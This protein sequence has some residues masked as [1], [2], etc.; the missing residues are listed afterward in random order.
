LKDPTHGI[1]ALVVSCALAITAGAGSAAT[2]TVDH[3]GDG[4][5][6]TLQE[7]IDAASVGDTLLVAPG[8][9]SGDGNRDLDF[10]GKNLAVLSSTGRDSTVIDCGGSVGEPHRGFFFHSGEDTT[11]VVSGITITNAVADSGAGVFCTG[12]VS[13][14]FLDCAFSQNA[15][16]VGGGLASVASSPIVR[17]CLFDGNDADAGSRAYGGGGIYAEQSV[18]TLLDVDFVGNHAVDDVGYGGAVHVRGT[19][20]VAT[21]CAFDGNWADYGGGIFTAYSSVTVTGCTFDANSSSGAGGVWCDSISDGV[22]EDCHFTGNDGFFGGGG[23]HCSGWSD[24]SVTGCTFTANESSGAGGGLRADGASPI[25]TDCVFTGN[26][27]FS[28]SGAGVSCRASAQPQF[29]DCVFDSNSAFG[30]AGGGL[31]SVN[32]SPLI[33][34]CTFTRNYAS[35]FGGGFFCA[36]SEPIMIDSE[37]T[38]NRTEGSGGGAHL[39]NMTHAEMTRCTFDG[40]T[41][42]LGAGL[43]CTASSPTIEE[44]LFVDN[45]ADTTA[46]ARG[47]AIACTSSDPEIVSCTLVGN[48]APVGGGIDC[49]DS[50]PTIEKTIIA[51]GSEG[52]AV[53]CFGVSQPVLS[54]TDVY[55]NA[56]GDWVGCIAFQGD[57]DGNRS[58]DP[59]FVDA[60]AGDY[61]LLADSPCIEPGDCALIGAFGAV[62]AEEPVIT[63]VRDVG[64]DEG[65]WV[66]LSWYRSAH[67]APGDTLFIASYALYRRPDAGRGRAVIGEWD[68]VESIPATGEPEYNFVTE[69]LCDS[70]ASGGVCWSVFAVRARTGAPV[71]YFDSVPDSG[72]SYDNVAPARPVDLYVGGGEGGTF[73]LNWE[74]NGEEDLDRYAVYRDTVPDFEPRQPL[75]FVTEASFTDDSPCVECWYRVSAW[76]VGGNESEPSD[77]SAISTGVGELPAR[78]ALGPAVP[79]PF[80]GRT[81]LAF[82]LPTES[83]VTA[84]VFE[85]SGRLVRV[86]LDYE[87]RAAGR[88]AIAWD[89][90][91]D[92]GRRVASGIYF[93]RVES[94]SEALARKVLLLR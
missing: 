70:T 62:Y 23:M 57:G 13:P 80:R 87:V 42:A 9:Y 1:V 5:Y 34:G 21:G 40:N 25:V 92:D 36:S 38:A 48:A 84:R 17:F 11:S 20:L 10:A 68:F 54:C 19:V 77:A 30:A 51:F 69:T 89:G 2:V 45:V 31:E 35:V 49:E 64:N 16:E 78:F 93:F 71:V 86:V 8:V 43:Y 6:L 33:S 52:E 66:R 91:N 72:Y 58:A 41:A 37:F 94:G 12:G 3:A 75:A 29:V 74:P 56:G 88:H 46:G 18:L 22:F 15:A 26:V 90:R 60:A 44:C 32:S 24:V 14:R 53:A 73:A 4:D 59:L 47:G 39:S 82:E 63:A 79:N 85:A 67:D 61:R 81:A 65:G 50:S 27:V 83:R 76:D 28:G 7:G 55:G